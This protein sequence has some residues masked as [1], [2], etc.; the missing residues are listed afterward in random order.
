MI[1]R[2]ATLL[3]FQSLTRREGLE[4]HIADGRIR[5]IARRRQSAARRRPTRKSS[6]ARGCT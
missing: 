5:R 3:D 4:V 1:L 6:T 2:G